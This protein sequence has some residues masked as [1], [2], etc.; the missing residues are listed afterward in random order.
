MQFSQRY[1]IREL[2]ERWYSLLYDPVISAEASGHMIE[3]ERSAPTLTSKFS[4]LGNSKDNKIFSGKRKTQSVRSCYYALR[5]RICNEPFKADDFNYRVGPSNGSCLRTVDDS[6]TGDYIVGGR[7]MGHLELQE[8]DHDIKDRA[9]PN[10]F[11]DDMINTTNAFEKDVGFSAE[12]DDLSKEIP[13]TPGREAGHMELFDTNNLEAKPFPA[14][15]PTNQNEE[16]VCQELEQNDV[17]NSPILECGGSFHGL[18]CSSPLPDMPIWKTMEGISMLDDISLREKHPSVEETFAI[19]DIESKNEDQPVVSTEG[20]F[21]ELSKSLLNFT[22]EE[23]LLFMD[24]DTKDMFDKS[25]YDGLSSLLLNSPVDANQEGDKSD[26]SEAVAVA[27]ASSTDVVLDEVCKPEECIVS[28]M[29]G[30]T[31]QFSETCDGF[32]LC[33]LNTEDSD[34][35]CNDDVV[36]A[37][38]FA[39]SSAF[40]KAK[41]RFQES[42]N[43]LPLSSMGEFSANQ[44]AL[45][46]G[47]SISHA[48]HHGLPQSIGS[49]I[50]GKNSFNPTVGPACG[51][52]CELS[53]GNVDTN[54]TDQADSST[55]RMENLPILT[56]KEEPLERVK[57]LTS[58]STDSALDRPITD[59]DKFQNQQ[60][61]GPQE[62]QNPLDSELGPVDPACLESGMGHSSSAPKHIES[63]EDLPSFSDIEA[64]VKFYDGPWIVILKGFFFLICHARGIYNYNYFFYTGT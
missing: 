36:F 15:A 42:S 27:V 60:I 25:Y 26:F 50:S 19:E 10:I 22:N 37:K 17:F 64:M 24:V 9:F 40:T 32:M 16:N 38:T 59:S 41:S 56:L 52:K 47:L 35:P 14:F 23:E 44:R 46:R 4:K 62:V 21:E 12:Q 55:I 34:I 6:L 57:H 20:Y 31:M 28:S 29:S 61:Y 18:D 45:E 5:K 7:S 63:D 33:T 58:N 8:S 30:S 51:I 53:N 1:T 48:H 49:Q 2:Q 43:C 54:L 3:F 13:G 39:P 11:M